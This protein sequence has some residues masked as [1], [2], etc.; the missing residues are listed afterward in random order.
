M[1]RISDVQF[2]LFTAQVS[3]A[4]L[5]SLAQPPTPSRNQSNAHTNSM[6]ELKGLQ[7]ELEGLLSHCKE[8]TQLL[9]KQRVMDKVAGTL[10]HGNVA[11][12]ERELDAVELIGD[13]LEEMIGRI[14]V[15]R[16]L[17]VLELSKLEALSQI[18]IDFTQDVSE[19]TRNQSGKVSTELRL[20]H[21]D[22]P[23]E[24]GVL[25]SLI[26]IRNTE[27]VGKLLAKTD[28]LDQELFESSFHVVNDAIGETYETC[29]QTDN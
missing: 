25:Q 7:N 10:L 14:N 28:R 18:L 2:R 16:D 8:A 11:S 13:T 9:S 24:L 5:N 3:Y 29:Q 15:T 22:F 27:D 21:I 12:M 6:A 17:L 20:K 19:A 1:S 23:K 26:G 4:Y